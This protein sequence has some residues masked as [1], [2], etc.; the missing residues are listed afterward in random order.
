M[1][2]IINTAHKTIG[3]RH[4]CYIIAEMSA[5]H[6]GDLDRAIEIIHAA[7]EAGADCIKIQTYTPDTITI[8]CNNEYFKIDNGTW[9]GETLYSL[10]GKAY[11]PW[12]WQPLLKKEADKVGIDFLSTPFDNTSVDFLEEIGVE[13]YKIASFELVDIPLIK[14]VASKGKPMIISTGMATLEEIKEAVITAKNN[15]CKEICLL[16]CSSSYPAIPKDMNLSTIP[17]MAK[18]FKVITGLSDHSLGSIAAITAVALGAKVI[19]KHFCISRDIE[20]PDSSFSMEKFEFQKMV[21][22]IRQVEKAIGKKVYEITD[23]ENASKVFRKSVFIVKDILS[24]EM[25]TEE[26]IRVIRPGWGL[27]PKYYEKI[28]GKH[29]ACD[30]K[31][32]QPLMKDLIL[33][34]D[35]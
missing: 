3:N 9:K 22:E 10:Y 35:L 31:R 6:A 15:G 8:D 4:P 29:A 11:T 16:K 25:F 19:E 2:N 34:N 21:E 1:N 32:G 24:G 30:L 5:N 7:K 17:D 13:F 18:R 27:Q 26:N 12:E 33:E 23:Q 28:I 20:N 14:Y